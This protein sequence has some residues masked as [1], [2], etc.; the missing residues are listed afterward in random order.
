MNS[1]PLSVPPLACSWASI[2]SPRVDGFASLVEVVGLLGLSGGFGSSPEH[3]GGFGSLTA[4]TGRL[5]MSGATSGFVVRT[6]ERLE[7]TGGVSLN[8][9]PPHGDAVPAL[10][11]VGGSIEIEISPWL[12]RTD[13]FYELRTMSGGLAFGDALVSIFCPSLQQLGPPPPVCFEPE[14]GL[15]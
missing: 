15:R 9:L 7:S 8:V 12:E 6:F 14:G 4:V 11:G 2:G 1:T 10:H 13:G 3:V 5:T